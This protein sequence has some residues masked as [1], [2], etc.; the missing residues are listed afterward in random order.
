MFAYVQ[1]VQDLLKSAIWR[2]GKINCI[3]DRIIKEFTIVIVT[4]L[5]CIVITCLF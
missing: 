1:R 3:N 4:V 2:C 5:N